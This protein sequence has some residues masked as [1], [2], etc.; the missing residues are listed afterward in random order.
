MSLQHMQL[1]VKVTFAYVR[2]AAL[3]L[4]CPTLAMLGCGVRCV[5]TPLV[6]PW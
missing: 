6:R 2:H 3:E 4:H 1:H 5:T